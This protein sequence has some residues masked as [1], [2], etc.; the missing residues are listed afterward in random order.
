MDPYYRGE[1]VGSTMPSRPIIQDLVPHKSLVKPD[2]TITHG[3][4]G[5]INQRSLPALRVF[6]T[7]FR[8]NFILMYNDPLYSIKSNRADK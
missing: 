2:P 3:G 8:S 7:S 1:I 5:I 6:R 4:A